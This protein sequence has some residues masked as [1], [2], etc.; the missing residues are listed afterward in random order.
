MKRIVCKIIPHRDNLN[1]GETE[2]ICSQNIQQLWF[3][4]GCPNYTNSTLILLHYPET[5][6]TMTEP[7][8]KNFPSGVKCVKFPPDINML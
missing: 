4:M 3:A 8:Q 5:T 6:C 2:T 1:T 7:L